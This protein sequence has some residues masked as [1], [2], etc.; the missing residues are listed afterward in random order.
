MSKNKIVEWQK[1]E[2]QH[3]HGKKGYKLPNWQEGA[4]TKIHHQNG[5]DGK[6]LAVMQ[7]NS[8]EWQKESKKYVAG[9]KIKQKTGRKINH[10]K[11]Q[12]VRL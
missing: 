9:S 8:A 12:K 3:C 4:K 7:K 5:K 1:V 11:G 2:L 10:Q 6:N